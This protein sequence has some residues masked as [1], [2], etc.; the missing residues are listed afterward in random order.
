MP[1][2]DGWGRRLVAADER[3]DDGGRGGISGVDDVRSEP[4]LDDQ[5]VFGPKCHATERDARRDHEDASRRGDGGDPQGMPIAAQA[6]DQ[7]PD[8]Q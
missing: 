5:G 6:P 7:E 2:V 8:P 3:R 1:Q 4:G